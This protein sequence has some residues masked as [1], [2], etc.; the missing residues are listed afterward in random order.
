MNSAALALVAVTI[1]TF[2]NSTG[3]MFFKLA[4]N[5]AEIE[6]MNY[7]KTW[8]FMVGFFIIAVAAIVTVGKF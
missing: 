8:Q 7:M 1:G 4:H 3:F 2:L 5:R 6:N